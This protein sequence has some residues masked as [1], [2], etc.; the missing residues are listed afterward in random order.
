[1]EGGLPTD[2]VRMSLEPAA[3][4]DLHLLQFIERAEGPVGQRLIG[5]GPEAFSRLQLRRVG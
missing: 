4:C 3:P 2:D 5:E 1:M